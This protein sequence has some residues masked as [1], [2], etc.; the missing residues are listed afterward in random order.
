MRYWVVGEFGSGDEVK[1]ALRRL[2]ELGYA[3]ETLDA[4]SPYPVEG[5]EEVLELKP[6]PLRGFAFVAGLMGAAFGYGVQWW[7]NAVDWPLNVGNRPP[8]AGPA[9]VP[10]TFEMMV[11]F[12]ALTLF[13]GLMWLYRFPRPHHPLFEL[14]SFRTASTGGFWV[15]VTTERR[16][17]TEPVLRHLRGLAARNTSVVEEKE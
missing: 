6:S 9:F 8:H 13:L 2:R 11:L 3:K 15:S 4:F 5:L 7:T 17:E 1:K 12:A 10:I 16:E 14:E